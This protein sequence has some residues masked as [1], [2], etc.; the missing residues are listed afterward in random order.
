MVQDSGLQRYKDQ[1]I[2]VCGKNL[3]PL[4]PHYSTPL[5]RGHRQWSLTWNKR[6]FF[7]WRSLFIYQLVLLE[8]SFIRPIKILPWRRNWSKPRL[9]HYLNFSL[10]ISRPPIYQ[11]GEG[12]IVCS[13]CKPLLKTC[14][15]CESKYSEPPIRCRFAEKLAAKYFKEDGD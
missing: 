14:C 9:I 3:V 15:L 7:K 5:Q 10:E 12:H 8:N 11:C 13:T 4:F 2:R 6:F 1:K